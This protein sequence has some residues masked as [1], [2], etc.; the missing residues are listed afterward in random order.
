MPPVYPFPKK[1]LF[2]LLAAVALQRKLSFHQVAVS[3]TNLLK[4][5]PQIYGGENI[6]G[7]GGYVLVINHY[8][9]PGFMAWWLALTSSAN[10]PEEVHW[11]QSNAWRMTGWQQPLSG[12][13][14]WLFPQV[15]GAL[16]FTAMP[17]IPPDPHEV[18]QRAQAVRKVLTVARINPQIIIGL[19]PEGS[20]E[21]GGCLKMPPPGTGRFIQLL[22]RLGLG[23]LPVGFFEEGD[24][25][26]LR[27][28]QLY[29]LDG[30]EGNGNHAN[31]DEQV[32]KTV[33]ASIAAQLP[34]K[35][36][37]EFKPLNDPELQGTDA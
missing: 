12:I 37:G 14:R 9:R 28:G 8:T 35:L 6:P 20:D 24:T 32:S 2:T 15:A 23:F 7:G 21:E 22:S 30:T 17:P 18:E 26:C 31:R 3:C 29:H 25:P 34:P 36:W 16:G 33:M 11:V 19:A 13:T 5:A 1:T 4:P 10:I 27:F